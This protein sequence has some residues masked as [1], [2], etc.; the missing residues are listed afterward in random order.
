ME[1]DHSAW[2]VKFRVHLDSVA[3]SFPKMLQGYLDPSEFNYY[4]FSVLCIVRGENE[5]DSVLV[6]HTPGKVIGYHFKSKTFKEICE[7]ETSLRLGWFDAYQYIETLVSSDY[8]GD[9]YSFSSCIEI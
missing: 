4:S 2:F 6:L 3:A 9:A 7:T 8:E 5:N 1:R